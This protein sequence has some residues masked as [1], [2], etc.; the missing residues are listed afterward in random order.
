M[1]HTAPT[2]T[3]T[4]EAR[5]WADRMAEEY[6]LLPEAT[7]LV[8]DLFTP[9][10]PGLVT[11][12]EREVAALPATSPLL[13]W[14]VKSRRPESGLDELLERLDTDDVA[15]LVVWSNTSLPPVSDG[16]DT[17]R[18]GSPRRYHHRVR[19]HF[20]KHPEVWNATTLPL[21]LR[22]VPLGMSSFD[23]AVRACKGAERATL[24]AVADEAHAMAD[25]IAALFSNSPRE[26]WPRE[27]NHH[28]LLALL[29]D[30]G[31]P[32]GPTDKVLGYRGDRFLDLLSS[33]HPDITSSPAITALFVHG[34]RPLKGPAW[35]TALPTYLDAVPD[36]D[37]VLRRVL[38]LV[39]D[40]PDVDGEHGHAGAG[41]WL[42]H[43]RHTI[44]LTV[45][46][47]VLIRG[48]L[49]IL[50]TRPPRNVPWAVGLLER[51]FT[52]L[53]PGK[54]RDTWQL[55]WGY[56]GYVG[57]LDSVRDET[58]IPA[59]VRIGTRV[60][61]T[62]GTRDERRK[63]DASLHLAARTNGLSAAQLAD[64]SVPDFGLGPDGTL[65]RRLGEHTVTLTATADGAALTFTGPDGRRAK[66]AP[67][68]LREDHPDGMKEFQGLARLV[69]TELKAQHARLGD[70]RGGERVWDLPDWLPHLV[71]HPLT[72]LVARELA[73]EVTT[74]GVA[75][76]T[77]A[78]AADGGHWRLVSPGGDTLLHTGRAAPDARVRLAPPPGQD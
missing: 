62:P 58:A 3:P 2:P 43:P 45:H 66:R 28:E 76:D 42:G 34:L 44:H 52:R 71:N 69:R 35:E 30:L 26:H 50:L 5:A 67:K 59:L 40:L 4:P 14:G 10:L 21:L 48:V 36:V 75:W 9:D 6:D 1:N 27:R 53:W 64:R 39:L 7:G 8:A 18:A 56:E 65:S 61:S 19:S 11:E 55:V 22:S 15:R 72:G 12:F 46:A 16:D 68:A 63:V 60:R 47:S 31:R 73:W 78:L 77:G 57:V 49:R 37:D 23:L 33:T 51:S 32:L 54:S 70:L 38:E 13:S 74:D 17:T 29:L 24:D 20:E 41:G 25:R